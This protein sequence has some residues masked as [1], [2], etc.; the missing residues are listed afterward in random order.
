MLDRILI[1]YFICKYFPSHYA[2]SVMIKIQWSALITQ[3]SHGFMR[4]KLIME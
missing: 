2:V 4:K 1:S 3:T